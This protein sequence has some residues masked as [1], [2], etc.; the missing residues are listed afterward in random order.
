L[1]ETSQTVARALALLR[2]FSRDEPELA[3][4]DLTRRLSLPR[5]I[6]IRLLSTLEAGQFVER[7][8]SGEY[9]IGLAACEIGA[10][11]LVRNPLVQVADEVIEELAESTGLTTYLGVAYGADVVILTLRE[12]RQPVRFTWS[13][14]DRLPIATT[15][16]GKAMLIHMAPHE[17]DQLVGT[18]RLTGLTER[19]VKN[20]AELDAQLEAARRRGWIAAVDESYPGIVAI[21]SAVLDQANRPIAG[22][23]LSMI[24]YPDDPDQYGRL[25]RDAANAITRRV[26]AYSAYGE[27]PAFDAPLR[28]RR[29]EPVSAQGPI[30]VAPRRG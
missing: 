29:P 11:H 18:E 9:R 15:A 4:T 30:R 1:R 10:L 8:A 23:S 28:M 3:V 17:L 6:V 19:S 5:T 22:I 16:L 2:E 24:G 26:V 14:G 13:A 27:R 7:S 25:V 20:R 12:G 21:G